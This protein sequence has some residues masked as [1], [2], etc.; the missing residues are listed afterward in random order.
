M[1]DIA[2]ADTQDLTTGDDEQLVTMTVDNQ[3]FGIPILKVQDIVEPDQI[4]P[5][6]LAPSAIA[7]VLN[8]R[9]R[10]VTV[11][12][13]RECL[14][15][16]TTDD[17]RKQMSVTVEYKGDLY[18]LLV[19]SIGD[20]RS[21]PRKSFDKAPATLD[22]N[23]KRVCSGIFRL[24]EDLLVVLDVERILDEETIKKTRPRTR[25][26][27]RPQIA[28]QKQQAKAANSDEKPDESEAEKKPEANTNERDAAKVV[29]KVGR[30]DNE[31]AASQPAAA[32]VKEDKKPA[33]AVEKAP[34]NP[35]PAAASGADAEARAMQAVELYAAKID[36]DPVLTDLFKDVSDPDMLD[37]LVALFNA[38]F[39]VSKTPTLEQA[40][41]KLIT[42][43][44]LADDHFITAGTALHSTL[45]EM[46]TSNEEVDKIM[47]VVDETRIKALDS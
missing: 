31:S 13:L 8:L 6:P 16:E 47:K 11:I 22:D 44:G 43:P 4:T 10:I 9:G 27:P 46:N 12:D 38:A 2:L 39:G 45:V 1:S 35:A 33:P 41:M 28:A 40:Y 24:E 19:D 14:G 26:R 23:L 32:K 20:V 15:A 29:L 17:Y 36:S 3:L 25:R 37:M 5:V 21:L 42:Q 7:G 18:T 30:K 34:D